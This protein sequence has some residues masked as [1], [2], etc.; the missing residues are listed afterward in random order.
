[1]QSQHGGKASMID[2][3]EVVSHREWIEARKNLL[4]KEKTF[5]RLRDQ[6]SQLRRDLPWE[7][8]EK[9]YV[10]EG[11]KGM[12]SLSDLF[13]GRSQ[14]IVVLQEAKKLD[15]NDTELVDAIYD[16]RVALF[17]MP[18]EFRYNTEART[19]WIR[20]RLEDY[21]QQIFERI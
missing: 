16:A 9:S 17:E 2:S 6:L 3:H 14:L 11:P 15:G 18:K 1:L 21:Q 13:G 19:K 7:L 10:F 12:E 5:T 8:V 20:D 4:E